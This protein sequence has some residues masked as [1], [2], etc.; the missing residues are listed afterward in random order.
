MEFALECFHVTS[1]SH[2]LCL[3]VCAV[4]I[5]ADRKDSAGT[6]ETASVLMNSLFFFFQVYIHIMFTHY[7]YDLNKNKG[8]EG[9]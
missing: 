5:K 6:A 1:W 7:I 8:C 4:H 9:W 3:C 2:A